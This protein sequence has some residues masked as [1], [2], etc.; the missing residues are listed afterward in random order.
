MGQV[1]RETVG[2]FNDVEMID[3]AINEL[4]STNF[5]RHDISVIA[6]RKEVRKEFGQGSVAPEL[7]EDNPKAPRGVHVRPEE[8]T[9]GAGVIIGVPAYVTGCVA[10][11][12]V[13]PASGPVLLGAVALGSLVGA[14]L[15]G[16][17]GRP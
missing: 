6:N 15:G 7:L 3:K 16:G 13:N 2:V 17:V 1:I 10:A 12:L 5:P 14:A 11:L 9:I 8:R 4:E